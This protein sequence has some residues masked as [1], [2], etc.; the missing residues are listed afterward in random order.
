MDWVDWG[1]GVSS[2]SL[3]VVVT[4]RGVDKVVTIKTGLDWTGLCALCLT[5]DRSVWPKRWTLDWKWLQSSLLQLW[6]QMLS[7]L[8][9]QLNFL[10]VGNQAPL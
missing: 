4:R 7:P 9:L 1:V 6:L 5:T 8:N 10:A 2:V 3:P